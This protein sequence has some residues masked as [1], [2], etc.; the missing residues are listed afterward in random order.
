MKQHTSPARVPV[1]DW[2]HVGFRI[3]TTIHSIGGPVGRLHRIAINPDTHQVSHFVVRTGWP[4]G[5]FGRTVVVPASC[6]AG[7]TPEGDLLF[8]L[9]GEEVSALPGYVEI[10]H[11]VADRSLA[12]PEGGDREW[13]MQPLSRG[14]PVL[15][16]AMV[17]SGVLLEHRRIG[18][19]GSAVLISR[20]DIVECLDGEVGH[21]EQV[22]SERETGEVTHLAIWCGGAGEFFGRPAAEDVARA[23][24]GVSLVI[25]ELR[26]T[27]AL[28]ATLLG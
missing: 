22:L 12:P 28:E 2:A 5:A 17:E 21:V 4:V 19:P 1:T 14:E 25:D 13:M 23:V 11:V 8:D 7:V 16:T 9:T 6:V 20:G 24:P 27:S 26:V 15:D 3:G 18:I 10:E